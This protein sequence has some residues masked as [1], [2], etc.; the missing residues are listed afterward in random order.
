MKVFLKYACLM[1]SAELCRGDSFLRTKAAR[2]E[3]GSAVQV[4]EAFFLSVLVRKF[5][6]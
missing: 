1:V 5:G 6:A 2:L 3:I 4:N